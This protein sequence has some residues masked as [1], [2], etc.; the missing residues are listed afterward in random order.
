LEEGEIKTLGIRC[1]RSIKK[2]IEEHPEQNVYRIEIT[3]NWEAVGA[4]ENSASLAA[5]FRFDKEYR[6]RFS[7]Q[8]LRLYRWRWKSPTIGVVEICQA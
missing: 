3:S 2:S 7:C 4:V 1:R 5:R 8:G 6:L